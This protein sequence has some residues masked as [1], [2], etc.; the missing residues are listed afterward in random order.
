M[1][2]ILLPKADD[3]LIFWTKTGNKS[4]LKKIANLTKAILNE[5]YL[6]LSKPEPLKHNLASKWSRRISEENRLVYSY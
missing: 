4:V 1:E 3:D 2:I 5:P 6:G